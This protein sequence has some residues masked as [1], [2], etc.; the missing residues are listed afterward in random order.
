MTRDRRHKENFIP[1]NLRVD[2]S[3]DV[4]GMRFYNDENTDKKCK[5]RK[6]ASFMPLDLNVLSLNVAHDDDHRR[7]Q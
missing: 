3:V 6:S 2:K 4:R 7:R 1:L 5:S